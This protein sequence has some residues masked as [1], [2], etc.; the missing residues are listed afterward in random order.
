MIFRL[1]SI[2]DWYVIAVATERQLLVSWKPTPDCNI[3]LPELIK[4]A[5]PELRVLP[6]Y[7]SDN[8]GLGSSF[9]KDACDSNNITFR[10]LN[11]SDGFVLP[12]DVVKSKEIDVVLTYHDGV[13]TLADTPCQLYLSKRSEFLQSLEPVDEIQDI[14][15]QVKSNYFKN[16]IVIGVHFRTHNS[17]FD[18]NVV[19]PIGS[20]TTAHKFGD[21]ANYDDFYSILNMISNYFKNGPI[22]FFI[23]SNDNEMKA[24]L[25]QQFPQAITI[26]GDLSRSSTDGIKF[27]FIEWLLLS[28]TDLI[29]NTYGSSYAVEAAGRKLKPII[30]IWNHL[31]IYHS[32]VRLAYCGHL[33][34]VRNF[35]QQGHSRT[36]IEEGTIDNRQVQGK[37]IALQESYAFENWGIP[38]VYCTASDEVA[39]TLRPEN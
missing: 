11:I 20:A 1:R 18:W 33:Q 32:D 15:R 19:P 12:R 7:I 8:I 25:I 22:K 6:F 13:I 4:S 3:T 5:A 29:V 35:S 37:V 31:L 34:Y 38:V 23:A 9:V 21:G 16:S 2:A 17:N 24:K 36:Y 30:G 26:N 39:K 27:A 14:V 10:Y 28:E